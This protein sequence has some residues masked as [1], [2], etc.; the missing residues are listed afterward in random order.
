MKEEIYD[1]AMEQRQELTALTLFQ[2]IGLTPRTAR[3]GVG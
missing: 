2:M 3:N 1:I